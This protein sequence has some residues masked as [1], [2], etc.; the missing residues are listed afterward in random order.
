VDREKERVL[1]VPTDKFKQ[2][3]VRQVKGAEV[4]R[5]ILPGGEQVP[6]SEDH[7]RKRAPIPL[8]A[9]CSASGSG[10]LASVWMFAYRPDCQLKAQVL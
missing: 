1:P 10:L 7:Y 5:H 4:S 2:W 3:E 8:L 6:T 9:K